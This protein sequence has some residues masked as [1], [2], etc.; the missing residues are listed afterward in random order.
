VES[1]VVAID[2]LCTVAEASACGLCE[3]AEENDAKAMLQ[4]VQLDEMAPCQLPNGL[5][6]RCCLQCLGLNQTS[7]YSF[8]SAPSSSRFGT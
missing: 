5:D 8:A 6:E 2:Q 4:Q 7:S 3:L 1:L